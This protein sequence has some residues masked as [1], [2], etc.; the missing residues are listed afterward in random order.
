MTL[1]QL[2]LIA[3]VQG[4]TE[5]LPISSSGHLILIPYLTDFPDQGPLI[6][7]AVHVGSLLAIIVYFFKDVLTLARGGFASIGIGA[8]REEAPAERRLFWWIV[9]GTIPA[10]VFG[11]AIKLGAFN[12]IAETWFG[13]TVTDQDLMASLRFTDLIAVNLI[14]YGILLGL[15]D[16]FGKEVKTFEDMTWR[17]GL[18]VGLAQALAIIP[19]TS[20]SG[21]TMTAARALGYSRFESARFSFLLSIPA[22]AGAGV[23]I[24]PEI[25]EAGGGLATEAL[26]AGVL[27][28]LAAFATMAFLMNFLKK[29]SMLVFVLY[30]IAMG[31]A[32]LAFF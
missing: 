19:G 29:A 10:V 21:V 11:L 8:S 17:D 7:V 1:V 30:R 20:R 32:L 13:I 27:T 9:L 4:I 23:L 16:R 25:F 26:I 14:V 22:V 12:S 3:I 2:L 5:F 18:L 15:A 28:F 6:D 24:V 31:V